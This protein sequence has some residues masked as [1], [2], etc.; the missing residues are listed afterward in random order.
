MLSPEQ[1]ESLLAEMKDT[2]INQ[3]RVK[4]ELTYSWASQFPS[5]PG[6]YSIFEDEEL[7]YV[8]ETG[9]IRERMRDILDTRHHT[10]KRNIGKQNFSN[11]PGFRAASSKKKFPENIEKMVNEWLLQKMSVSV[12]PLYLGRKELEVFIFKSMKK[13]YNLKGERKTK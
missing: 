2:L 12:M 9:N 11:A 13:T 1:I 3:P 6:V 4:I 5:E 10:L 8:G 7:V